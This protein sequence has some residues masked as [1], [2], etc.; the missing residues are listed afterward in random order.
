MIQAEAHVVHGLD[1][2]DDVDPVAVLVV[3]HPLAGGVLEDVAV[4]RYCSVHGTQNT[5]ME[6]PSRR[7]E[8]GWKQWT[9]TLGKD[10]AGGTG[11]HDMWGTRRPNTTHLAPVRVGVERAGDAGI[12][13]GRA[14]A[15][16]ARPARHL[17]ERLT[18]VPRP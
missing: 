14:E 18:R 7:G 3:H 1:G 11:K 6:T 10:V 9:V 2:V 12:V 17:G 4:V 8:R 15:V 16:R 13:H 5:C